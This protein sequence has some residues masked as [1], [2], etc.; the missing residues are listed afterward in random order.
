MTTNCIADTPGTELDFYGT[1]RNSLTASLIGP[2]VT[3][4]ALSAGSNLQGTE[5]AS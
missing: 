4:P 5:E 2:H 3:I 1:R